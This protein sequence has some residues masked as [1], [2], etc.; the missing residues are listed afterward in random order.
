MNNQKFR[1]VG[2]KLKMFSYVSNNHVLPATL[3]QLYEHKILEYN[4]DS[5][6]VIVFINNLHKLNKPQREWLKTKNI[7]ATHG[8]IIEIILPYNIKINHVN[9]N[10]EDILLQQQ[11]LLRNDIIDVRGQSKGKGFCGVMKLFNFSGGPAS[12]GSS[13]FHRR[14]GSLSGVHSK[15]WKGKKM[16]RKHGNKTIYK[17]NI[18]VLEPYNEH[19]QLL[20]LG[21]IPGNNYNKLDCFFYF[22]N[23]KHIQY[24]INGKVSIKHYE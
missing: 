8:E 18:K 15:I 13:K 16:P 22:K 9:H 19:K 4:I 2:R 10:L 7:D 5:L 6:K 12:H 24:I 21:G 1:L 23:N 14:G 17:F 3:I 20:L 11:S